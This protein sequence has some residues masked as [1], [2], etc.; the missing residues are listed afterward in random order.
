M[1][2][3]VS[4]TTSRK[5]WLHFKGISITENTMKNAIQDFTSP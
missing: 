4:A 2:V 3:K 1:K 5:S